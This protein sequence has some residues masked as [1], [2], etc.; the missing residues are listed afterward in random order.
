MI[1]LPSIVN[2]YDA[3]FF[4]TLDDGH[5]VFSLDQGHSIHAQAELVSCNAECQYDIVDAEV[6]PDFETAFSLPLTLLTTFDPTALLALFS[7]TAEES[8]RNLSA[9]YYGHLV[10]TTPP[11]SP[12]CRN[13]GYSCFNGGRQW[14]TNKKKAGGDLLGALG[15][16]SYARRK[17]DAQWSRLECQDQ[18]RIT[19]THPRSFST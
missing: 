18:Q 16:R 3:C 8:I 5:A 19:N 13:S 7:T 15:S 1:C 11:N 4:A 12:V 9:H 17:K 2:N 14:L 10:V 6:P